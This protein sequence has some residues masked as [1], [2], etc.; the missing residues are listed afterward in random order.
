MDITADKCMYWT[1]TIG[2][3]WGKNAIHMNHVQK[4]SLYVRSTFTD[5][6]FPVMLQWLNWLLTLAKQDHLVRSQ[7]IT[8]LPH[9]HQGSVEAQKMAWVSEAHSH[10]YPL[11]L[12]DH[13]K[14]YGWKSM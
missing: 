1:S 6:W 4:G 10:M 3:T 14:T 8:N 12:L 7:S 11:L 13:R 9:P 5:C 2:N